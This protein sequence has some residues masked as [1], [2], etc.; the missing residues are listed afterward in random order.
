MK[1]ALI[2]TLCVA[3]FAG[4]AFGQMGTYSVWLQGDA[5]ANTV[6]VEVGGQASFGFWASY[7]G[8]ADARLISMDAQLR[9]NGFSNLNTTWDAQDGAA[10]QAI[11]AYNQGPT[12][13]DG[14]Q[15][16]SFSD[17]GGFAGDGAIPTLDIY[18]GNLNSMGGLGYQF[19]AGTGS[20]PDGG[21]RGLQASSTSWYMDEIVIEGL[22]ANWDDDG[23][24]VDAPDTVCF[25]RKTSP[26]APGFSET[27]FY[28]GSW[29]DQGPFV[30][31][32]DG[33]GKPNDRLHVRVVTPEPASLALLAIGGLAAIRRRR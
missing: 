11:G 22:V 12:W 21:E 29:T 19:A 2:S 13:G 18:A 17:H 30:G 24:M 7:T 26:S 1:R 31:E 16:M 20:Y 8:T 9:H 32:Q 5:G 15:P 27:Q 4:V 3:L 25:P 10:F 23:P 33:I 28:G 6:T 14:E